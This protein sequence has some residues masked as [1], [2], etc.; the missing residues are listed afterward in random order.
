MARNIQW[1]SRVREEIRNA[2]RKVLE[3]G[4][5]EFTMGDLEAMSVMQATMKESMRLHPIAWLLHRTAEQDDSIP[6]WAQITTKSGER[7]SSVPVCKGQNI[8]ISISAYSR[9]V[10]SNC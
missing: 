6:L 7:I 2:R 3:R 4:E 8:E 1:Q 9:R 5:D 10:L